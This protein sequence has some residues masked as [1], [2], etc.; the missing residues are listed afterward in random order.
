VL[1]TGAAAAGAAEYPLEE[2]PAD[3]AD[4]LPP[5]VCTTV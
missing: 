5:T 1:A 4:A 3:A 2:E